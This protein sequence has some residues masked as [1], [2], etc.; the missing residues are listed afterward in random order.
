MPAYPMLETLGGPVRDRRRDLRRPIPISALA[1]RMSDAGS[2][3]EVMLG[4][5]DLRVSTAK[6]LLAQAPVH[7][8]TSE[9]ISAVVSLAPDSQFLPQRC[10]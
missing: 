4:L 1:K 7:E 5:I 8:K 2:G 6:S 3:I 9:V 10:P